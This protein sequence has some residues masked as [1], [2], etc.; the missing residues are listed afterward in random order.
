[1]TKM[2]VSANRPLEDYQKQS[3]PWHNDMQE[4]ANMA[5]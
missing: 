1:M 5:T 4:R 2:E 3:G